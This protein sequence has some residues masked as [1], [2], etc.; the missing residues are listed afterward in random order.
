VKTRFGGRKATNISCTRQKQST[1]E[2]RAKLKRQR[3]Q[4][5]FSD[6][7]RWEHRAARGVFV[8]AVISFFLIRTAA[9]EAVQ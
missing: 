8:Q 9:D 7:P 1:R 2:K 6:S 4:P 5:G 3:S